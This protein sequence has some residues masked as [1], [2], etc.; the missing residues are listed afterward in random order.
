VPKQ[1]GMKYLH[2]ACVNVLCDACRVRPEMHVVHLPFST[3][4]EGNITDG[5]SIRTCLHR[6]TS[7]VLAFAF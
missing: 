4:E 5:T 1:T 7:V 6:G 2:V 3:E